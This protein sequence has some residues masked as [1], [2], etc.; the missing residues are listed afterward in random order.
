MPTDLTPEADT[1]YLIVEQQEKDGITRQLL[2]YGDETIVTYEAQGDFICRQKSTWL[3]WP[4][5]K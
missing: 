2:D 4:E 3:H 1:A 5:Q